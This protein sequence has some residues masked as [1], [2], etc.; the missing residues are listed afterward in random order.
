MSYGA[1]VPDPVLAIPETERDTPVELSSDTCIIDGQI[2]FVLGCS[3]IPVTGYP[4]RQECLGV[5]IAAE[6]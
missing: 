2:F 1:A 3:E 4:L 5:S 6:L